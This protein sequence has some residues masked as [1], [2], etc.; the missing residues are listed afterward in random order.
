MIEKGKK[1]KA[2]DV[3]EYRCIEVDFK[4][5]WDQVVSLFSK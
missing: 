2:I 3:S 1:F 5:D 4:E